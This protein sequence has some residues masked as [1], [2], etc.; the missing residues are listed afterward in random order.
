MKKPIFITILFF[1]LIQF[2]S[3]EINFRGE[4]R[5]GIALRGIFNME[6]KD[7]NPIGGMRGDDGLYNQPWLYSYFAPYATRI[8]LR[9]D[10]NNENKTFGGFFRLHIHPEYFINQTNLQYIENKEPPLGNVWWQPAPQF[11]AT[12][13]Y[14]AASRGDIITSV[15]MV[16]EVLMPVTWWGRYHP[17]RFNSSW[18]NRLVHAWGWEEEAVGVSA[19][20]FNPFNIDGFYIAATLPLLQEYRKFGLGEFRKDGI[21]DLPSDPGY[22]ER[23]VPA[24]D[25][26][27]QTGVRFVYS[28]RGFGA[29]VVSWDGGTGRI[30]RYSS[31]ANKYGFDGQFI[32]AKIN[33]TSVKNLLATFGVEIPLPITNY[34]RGVDFSR[35]GIW[36]PD[37]L[38]S[39]H[40]G[41]V[42][43]FPYGIDM[44][45]QYS[46]GDF[47]LKSSIAMYIGGFLDAPDWYEVKLEG[48]LI[49]DPFEIGISLNPVY[50]LSKMELGLVGEFKFV[51]YI[52]S[53]IL[54]HPFTITGMHG[55]RGPWVSYNIVPYVSTK[56]I[57][58]TSAWTGLQIRG[59]PYT[60]FRD[61]D[62][63]NWKTLIQWSVP[64]GIA[65]VY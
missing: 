14:F 47:S 23:K 64:V 58:G 44:R 39:R 36:E 59:Q 13:G 43:Q 11:K 57:S 29:L 49:K 18:T 55:D 10:I 35:S 37:A 42:R 32:N 50:K 60:G 21:L 48:G 61:D 20:I 28:I 52:N 3:A 33:L 19:E 6:D 7:G 30:V 2:V 41:F 12:F 16:D 45:I 24:G 17:D 38:K 63:K 31:S 4:L 51:E 25:I 22:D 40:G 1:L 9:A 8:R 46:N 15:Y 62:G 65:Y 34:Y 5:A 54:A 56:I 27:A 53:N 26:L